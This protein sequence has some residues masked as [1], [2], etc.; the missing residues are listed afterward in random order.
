MVF[1][2][3]PTPNISEV[4]CYTEQMNMGNILN[5]ALFFTLG[6][7]SYFLLILAY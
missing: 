1:E 3:E 2:S 7:S 5:H 6:T 4:I